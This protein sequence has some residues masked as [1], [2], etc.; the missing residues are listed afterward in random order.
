MEALVWIALGVGAWWW[1]K[2]RTA[3]RR[4]TETSSSSARPGLV[5]TVTTTGST[6]GA[7]EK[8]HR[9]VGLLTESTGSGWVLNPLSPLPLTLHGA[10]RQLAEKVKALLGSDR[11][12][13]KTSDLALLIAKHNLR[14]KEV[15]TFI[16]KMKGRYDTHVQERI[17]ASLE[18]ASASENDRQ[19]LLTEFQEEAS[20]A[21]G[22]AVGRA[23]LSILLAGEPVAFQADDELLRHFDKDIDLYPFYLS[24]LS[25]ANSVVTVKADDWG[26]KSWERLT[27]LG[28]A[29]RGREIPTERLL[30]GLRL[31]DLNELLEGMVA[32]PFGRKARAI[33]ALIAQPDL[34]IRLEKKIAFRE[35]FQAIP[36]ADVD[37]STLQAS[38]S[39]AGEV[40]K[41]VQQTYATAVETLDALDERKSDDGFYNAWEIVNWDSPT[42]ACAQPY[43]KKYK[44]LPAKRPPFH[45]GCNCHLENSHDDE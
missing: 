18:W 12:G 6:S 35:M 16:E 38:L 2:K 24:Q 15:D 1:F 23:D 21:L 17:Q 36:P 5:L 44:K 22:V 20:G 3:G 7:P 10:D 39:Y 8:Q 13:R 26:R 31:K 25:R 42:P 32:K 30:E 43:C 34:D 29:L 14:F 37:L 19:D 27:N 4:G 9:D 28:L 11:W 41:V 40:A 45:V 33:E